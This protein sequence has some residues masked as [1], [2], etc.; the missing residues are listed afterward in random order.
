[1]RVP[2]FLIFFLICL[3]IG[4]VLRLVNLS[5]FLIYP[6]SYQNLVIAENIKTYTSVVGY[7][8]EQGMQYPPFIPWSRFGYPLIIAFLSFIP[9]SPINIAGI[10]SVLFGILSLP[11]SYLLGKTFIKHTR[12]GLA[13]L[14]LVSLSFNHTVWGGFVLTETMGVMLLL[15]LFVLLF[16]TLTRTRSIFLGLIFAVCVIT[17][18]EYLVIFPLIVFFLL[19]QKA[20]REIVLSF[21]LSFALSS[22][23]LFLAFFPTRGL[24]PILTTQLTPLMLKGM[25]LI[26]VCAVL[27]L[28]YRIQPAHKKD[29][30]QTDCL[31]LFLVF[32]LALTAFSLS[33][34]LFPTLL[35]PVQYTVGGLSDFIRHDF[36]LWI[37]FL[38][39]YGLLIRDK[40]SRPLLFFLT[41]ALLLLYALYHTTNPLMERYMT[42]LI[43]FLIL[44]A[45]VALTKSILFL[46]NPQNETRQRMTLLILLISCISYQSYLSFN[47]I[48]S[49]AAGSYYLTSYEQEAGR[50]LASRIQDKNAM[51]IASFPEAYFITTTHPTQSLYDHPPFLNFQDFRETEQVIIIQDAGMRDIFPTFS[52]FL[53]TKLK[54]YRSDS[55][56]VDRYY[57]YADKTTLD[58][59][60]VILYHISTS[61]LKKII[62][63]E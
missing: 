11:L 2:K 8:G 3:A 19:H 15:L 46:T 36:L 48:K 31:S 23:L 4:I 63:A 16:S 14:L 20:K 27:L 10:I 51:L 40:N 21:L 24:L 18:F 38:L 22:I 43:P 26:T 60:P 33:T 41:P 13:A 50:S 42:H 49:Y 44:P 45:S 29:R 53:E 39:G 34:Q 28:L 54:N 6:D 1:M 59:K 58:E 25:S 7:L 62:T 57:H 32:G 47:G 61:E 56:T 35:L 37:F 9:V 30:I 17:R 52:T 12:N 5:P 55:F